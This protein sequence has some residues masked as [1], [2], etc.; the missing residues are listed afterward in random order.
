MCTYFFFLYLLLFF[1]SSR[2]LHTRCAL[3]TGVQTCAL[4]IS[5]FL[6]L[7]YRYLHAGRVRF[8]AGSGRASSEKARSDRRHSTVT[9]NLSTRLVEHYLNPPAIRGH[10]K[11][12]AG[13]TTPSPMRIAL[14]HVDRKSTRLNSSH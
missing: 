9:E 10:A 6:C 14:K 3:L 8:G 13:H 5:P 12:D 2:R 4:P 11:S 1:F 7:S